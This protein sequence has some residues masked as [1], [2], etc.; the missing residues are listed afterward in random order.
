MKVVPD[1]LEGY[2]DLE[3]FFYIVLVLVVCWMGYRTYTLQTQRVQSQRNARSFKAKLPTY[4]QLNRKVLKKRSPDLSQNIRQNPLSYLER[5][6]P[7]R[8]LTDLEPIDQGSD[9]Y[10]FEL[11]VDSTDLR[12][13]L[14][15]LADFERQSALT[16]NE[17]TLIRES[18]D[19]HN[20]QAVIRFELIV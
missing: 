7:E 16:V 18:P 19:T 2:I 4:Q 17:F 20:F 14:S 8:Y 11:R 9:D 3:R 5:V 12:T 1:Y 6:V 10:R 13:I 15:L